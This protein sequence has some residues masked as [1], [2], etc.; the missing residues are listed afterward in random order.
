MFLLYLL[1]QNTNSAKTAPPTLFI[2]QTTLSEIVQFVIKFN[3]GENQK[4]LS[5]VKADNNDNIMIHKF[6]EI[7]ETA[8]FENIKNCV[9]IESHYSNVIK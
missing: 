5:V 4:Y 1:S 6:Y 9:N 2:K 8:E 7:H 3:K